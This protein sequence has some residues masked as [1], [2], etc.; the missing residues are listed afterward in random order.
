MFIG[1]V[2]HISFLNITVH[3]YND[4]CQPAGKRH[5]ERFKIG[6]SCVHEGNIACYDSEGTRTGYRVLIFILHVVPIVDGAH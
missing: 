1:R 3:M 4:V 6:Y 2:R 5:L